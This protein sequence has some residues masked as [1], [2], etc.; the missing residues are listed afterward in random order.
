MNNNSI[1]L[2]FK[3]GSKSLQATILLP[4]HKKDTYR[5]RLAGHTNSVACRVI[6][7]PSCIGFFQRIY[8]T[9]FC[10]ETTATCTVV[11]E[12]EAGSIDLHDPANVS[13][14][15]TVRVFINKNSLK[16]RIQDKQAIQSLTQLFKASTQTAA[17]AW[18]EVDEQAEFI[19]RPKRATIMT[20][21]YNIRE[22]DPTYIADRVYSLFFHEK[23]YV[24]Y[25][26]GEHHALWDQKTPL[27]KG[28]EN[29]VYRDLMLSERGA[30]QNIARRKSHCRTELT[31]PTPWIIRKKLH[32]LTNKQGIA[33]PLGTL[34][35]QTRCTH[36]EERER[37][38]ELTPF[39]NQGS[40][41]AV[42]KR[43]QLPGTYAEQAQAAT[44]LLEGLANL[45]EAGIL[46]RDIKP[47]NILVHKEGGKLSLSI[48][49]FGLACLLTEDKA[50]AHAGMTTRQYLPPEEVLQGTVEE[51]CEGNKSITVTPASD[52]WQMGITLYQLTHA[53]AFPKPLESVWESHTVEDLIECL[54][55]STTDYRQW[56]SEAEALAK[57]QLK[58][59]KV[60][61][62][63]DL[64]V[65]GM[66]HPDPYKRP[67]ARKALETLTKSLAPLP[68]AQ[69]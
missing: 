48:A 30:L 28:G 42:M 31:H 27:G 60:E 33:A 47:Q 62:H 64:L 23:A 24:Y 5:I 20:P 6:Q 19:A 50:Q 4:D 45:H 36:T 65:L 41:D 39:Y 53:G 12:R 32:T 68:L 49:D 2:T 1:G 7:D 26:H 10:I 15:K 59:G 56:W 43:G 16:K 11:P 34:S 51:L 22:N 69:A 55:T 8:H 25:S 61:A 54:Q 66:I 38:I 29:V 13:F 37:Y 40:L 58:T 57:T 46:H 35:Y 9:L 14:E 3:D 18:S 44:Q 21:Q 67:S 52:L 63:L 17:E